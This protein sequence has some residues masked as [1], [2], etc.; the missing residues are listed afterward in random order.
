MK[1]LLVVIAALAGVAALSV[2][3]VVATSHN[4]TEVRIAARHL[5]DGRIEVALQQREPDGSWGDRLLPTRRFVPASGHEGRWLTSSPVEVAIPT[6]TPGPMLTVDE[7]VRWCS[8]V[9]QR[10]EA[11]DTEYESVGESLQALLASFDQSLHELR[12]IEPPAVLRDYHNSLILLLAVTKPFFEVAEEETILEDAYTAFGI[13]Y[14]LARSVEDEVASLPTDV[15]ATLEEAGCIGTDD[16]PEGPDEAPAV[17]DSPTPVPTAV[18]TATATP[19]PTVEATAQPVP[20]VADG[21]PSWRTLQYVIDRGYLLC[22]TKQT[23]PLFGF[24]QYDGSVVGFDIEFCK[25][26]AAAVLGDATKVEYVD[27]SDASKRFEYL[28]EAEFDVLIRTTAVTA[29]RDRALGIDFTQPIFYSGQGFLV[30]ADSGYDST[31]DLGDALICVPADSVAEQNVADYFEEIGLRYDRKISFAV[32]VWDAFLSGRCDVLTADVSDIASR[33]AWR[34]DGVDYTILPQ[35]ISKEPLAP[36]VR[37]YDSEW[38]DVVNWV[39]LGLI[40]AEE[41][42]ITQG[43]VAAIAANPP[44]PEIA[45]LLGVTYEGGEVWTL[46]FDSIGAQFIQRAIA[47]VG[48]YGEIYERT[49]GDHLPRACTLNALASDRSVDCPPGQGGILYAL[50]YR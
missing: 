25:A 43:N 42:G 7:Y 26:I 47:A 35:L 36:V 19:I 40:A 21:P 6:V 11:A 16:E 34:N 22:G 27:A 12:A 24:K 15:R 13:L 9:A 30:R 37:D 46:G 17:S 44:N 49:I 3:V 20:V 50:P 45:R 23:Q 2:G 1:T 41:L 14:V 4:S 8:N 39:V 18:V 38:K 10:E 48:N 29:S 5:D 32:D 28:L 31:S 33:V